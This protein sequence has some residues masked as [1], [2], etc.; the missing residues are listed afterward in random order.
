MCIYSQCSKVHMSIL[1]GIPNS[2]SWK[3]KRSM[4]A[5]RGSLSTG[6]IRQHKQAQAHYENTKAR[7]SCFG[8]VNLNVSSLSLSVVPNIKSM[9]LTIRY[10]HVYHNAE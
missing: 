1:I 4:V 2:W 5:E 8:Y 3:A 6:R 7:H 9:F 10:L